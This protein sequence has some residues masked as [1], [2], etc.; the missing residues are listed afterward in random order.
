VVLVGG[1]RSPT[2]YDDGFFDPLIARLAR[3]GPYLFIRFGV[4][5]ATRGH[6]Y[7]TVGSISR[8][9]DELRGLI[10]DLSGECRAT[11]VISHSMGGVVTDRALA[12][13][14]A[15][16][17]G[18]VTASCCVTVPKHMISTTSAPD[19]SAKF[20]RLRSVS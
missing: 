20:P 10:H 11:H 17:D 8:N 15:A 4:E 7:D 6:A 13:G 1:L 18:L 19:C 14:H 12:K 5:P 3:E 16:A 2:S 9:A